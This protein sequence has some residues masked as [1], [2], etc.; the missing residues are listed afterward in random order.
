[1][2]LR[3]TAVHSRQEGKHMS[4]GGYNPPG[5]DAKRNFYSAKL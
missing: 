4:A 3:E 1:M 5:K 2:V